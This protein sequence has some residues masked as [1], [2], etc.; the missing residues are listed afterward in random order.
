MVGAPGSGRSGASC[1]GALTVLSG[2]HKMLNSK[3]ERDRKDPWR[4]PRAAVAWDSGLKNVLES[5]FQRV[6]SNHD[7]RNQN[8]LSCH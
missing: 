8:P 7:K 4:G 3:V 2:Y 6:D 5:G 1:I